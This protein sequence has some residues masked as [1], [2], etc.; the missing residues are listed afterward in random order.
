[1]QSTKS[2][3]LIPARGGAATQATSREPRP[4]K[5][6]EFAAERDVDE[7]DT[8]LIAALLARFERGAAHAGRN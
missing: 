7:R 2:R 4:A 3:A 1:M 6:R 5:L 8:S